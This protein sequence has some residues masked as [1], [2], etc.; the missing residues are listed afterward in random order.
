MS[1]GAAVRLR[2]FFFPRPRE[3]LTVSAGDSSS[4]SSGLLPT[5]TV[6]SWWKGVNRCDRQPGG[7]E[8]F[9]FARTPNARLADVLERSPFVLRAELGRSVTR[10][11]GIGE[12][13][14]RF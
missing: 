2:P 14:P 11:S 7:Y 5:P 10:R 3:P 12:S 8:M 9:G 6:S 1:A 13:H 4:S